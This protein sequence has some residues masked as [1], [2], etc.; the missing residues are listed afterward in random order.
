MT[1]RDLEAVELA[2]EYLAELAGLR[3]A[4]AQMFDAIDEDHHL[5][6]KCTENEDECWAVLLDSIQRVA[7]AY[8]DPDR[9]PIYLAAMAT[10]GMW[11]NH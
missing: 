3:P 11:R 10:E 5:R 4:A 2:P 6:H 9:V 1:S 8:E 7:E